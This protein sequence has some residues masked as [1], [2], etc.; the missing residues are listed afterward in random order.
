M[1]SKKKC[2]KWVSYE[3]VLEFLKWQFDE[4][5]ADQQINLFHVVEGEINENRSE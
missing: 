2:Q 4:D 5:F 1:E 3:E